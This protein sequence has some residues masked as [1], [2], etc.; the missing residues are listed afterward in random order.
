MFKLN[1][2][3]L[4]VVNI[5]VF[6]LIPI[7]TDRNEQMDN[8]YYVKDDIDRKV[9]VFQKL[10][11]GCPAGKVRFSVIERRKVGV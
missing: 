6:V 8:C 10:L 11:G 9:P 2:M 5:A 1:N 7:L 4:T 3:E